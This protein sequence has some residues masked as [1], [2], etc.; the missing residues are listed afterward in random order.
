MNFHC[1]KTIFFEHEPRFGS[2]ASARWLASFAIIAAC[3][4]SGCGDTN[5]AKIIGTWGIEQADKVLNRIKQNDD[6]ERTT[7]GEEPRMKLVFQRNGVL[8]TQTR[9]GA[10]TTEKQGTWKLVSYD[11]AA[12]VLSLECE[13]MQQTSTHAVEFVDENTIR[14]VPPNM[15]GLSMKLTFK[16]Q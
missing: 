9:L 15:A 3:T 8:K 12:G 6:S 7:E 5:R 10:G 1:D 14:L 2:A 16:R 4:I 13:L 11:E